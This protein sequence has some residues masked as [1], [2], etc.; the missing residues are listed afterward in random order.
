NRALEQLTGY[1]RNEL[2]GQKPSLLRSGLHPPE[3]YA[4]L[5]STVMARGVWQG[6]LTN[7]CKDGRL[8]EVALTV[9]P[10]LDAHGPV[11]HLTGIVRDV[12]ERKHLERQLM[13]AQK[14]QGVGT[15]AAGVA[16]EFNN[17]L[18]GISGYASLALHEQG[19]SEPAAE[20]MRN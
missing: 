8:V 2:V 3:V 7:R 6:E 16:H 5:W 14:M 9:S 20:L 1:Q 15:L 19:L 11:T 13:Q 18:A 12:S 17:L 10:V 4:N